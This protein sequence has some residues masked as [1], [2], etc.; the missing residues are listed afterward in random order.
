[1]PLVEGTSW[2]M[3][4][5]PAGSRLY[6]WI[7][8]GLLAA[9][10]AVTTWLVSSRTGQYVMAVRDDEVA[11]ASLGV[12]VLC[13]KLVA[14]AVSAAVTAVAGVFY[15]QYYLYVSP[16]LGLACPCRRSCPR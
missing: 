3:L 5:F 13:H 11:A 7:P 8:L 4:Q 14:V 6:L 9:A 10:L 16:D 15:V 2:S 1:V 12:D